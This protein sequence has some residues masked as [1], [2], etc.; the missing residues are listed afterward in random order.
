MKNDGKSDLDSA[1]ESARAAWVAY[2]E[3]K[4]A[5]LNA[6]AA[7]V[8]AE[9]AEGNALEVMLAAAANARA[10]WEA[11]AEKAEKAKEESAK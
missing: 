2:Q 4:T 11:E 1:R 8:A 6:R 5:A 10:E 7:L 3:A 9:R